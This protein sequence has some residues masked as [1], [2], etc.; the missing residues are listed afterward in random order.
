MDSKQ[1][2]NKLQELFKDQRII[3]WYDGGAEFTDFITETSLEDV[4]IWNLSEHGQLET[5]IE[6]EQTN[7]A[8]KYLLYAPFAKPDNADNWLLD[9]LLYSEEFRADKAA[10]LL[11][12][13]G[14]SDKPELTEHLAKR[15][16]FF[17]SKERSS[18]FIELVDSNDDVT[19]VDLKILTVLTKA[20]Y[21]SIDDILLSLLCSYEDEET[22]DLFSRANK[23]WD[24]I[25]K[26]GMA[27][28]F[29]Q[30]IEDEFSFDIE[31]KS[32]R[33]LLTRLMTCHL[34]HQLP[35]MKLPSLLHRYLLK[36]TRAQN[37]AAI[38]ISR[39]MQN[40]K[41][42]DQFEAYSEE[43]DKEIDIADYLKD[44]TV[45]DLTQTDCFVSI[46]KLIIRD[47]INELL[48]NPGFNRQR[49]K[50]TISERASKF[51]IDRKGGGLRNIYEAL[52][53][54]AELLDLQRT[55]SS[56]F[57]FDSA[58]EM[59]KAYES[60]LY[61]F[62]TAYRKFH[63]ALRKTTMAD[64]LKGEIREKVENVYINWFINNLSREWDR[65]IA[66][67]LFSNWQ[68]DS[69]T[70][71]Q[72]DFF[73]NAVS[74]KLLSDGKVFVII[75]DAMRYEVAAELNEIINREGSLRESKI[76]GM[77]GVL[78]SYTQLGM[79]ALLPHEE[80]KIND[81]GK[82]EIDNKLVTS[83]NRAE[84]IKAAIQ[85]SAAIQAEDLMTMTRQEGRGFL[86]DK[87]LVYVYHNQIDNIGDK[88]GTELRTFD[89]VQDTLSELKTMVNFI[90]SSLQVSR[91]LVTAD[92]G[93]LYQVN[94]MA[95][96]D[97]SSYTSGGK[98]YIA[99]KRYIIGQ[100]LA[101]Q[102]FAFKVPLKTVLGSKSS[103]EVVVPKGDGRFHFKGGARFVHGGAA[104]QEICVP[105]VE[106]KLFKGK[107]GDSKG[108]VEKVGV[109]LLDTSKKVTALTK[110]IMLFQTE[111]VKDKKQPVSLRIG[112][113][114]ENDEAISDE[115]II[116]FDSSNENP[117]ERQKKILVTLKSGDYKKNVDYY[118]M[119]VDKDTAKVCGRYP[120]R[121]SLGF[122]TDEFGF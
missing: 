106:V 19:A 76:N 34:N 63:F 103:T 24:E 82:V 8:G 47:I 75:S 25:V 122:S 118:L 121:I 40:E 2:I 15:S 107:K 111:P 119:L 27:E 71:R 114:T 64:I 56:S 113:Y 20:S 92:H 21:A 98:E 11:N 13:L 60:S 36:Q 105:L 5:K 16:D 95:E 120:Y 116:C 6:L 72:Q 37:H 65:F 18:R 66:N 1:I 90:T 53:A 110:S 58:A 38:F 96:S 42:N 88:A 94:P 22:D 77:L 68:L 32:L 99:K 89:A 35:K 17:K 83:S 87:K 14:L 78:P 109:E 57:S 39:W 69:A 46:D 3:F 55:Y 91:V 97:R 43:I 102:D 10:I 93:F 84:F 50:Q 29:W 48:N 86:K 73:R 79:A 59:F 100:D 74:P 104:L 28:C 81:E 4:S 61:R 45:N 9:V 49:L 115:Q 80:L 26:F 70:L 31:N 30:F 7:P 41:L 51:W 33:L 44:L 67:D 62:D 12:E 117:Q 101:E 23:R 108:R 85:E 112:F 52:A 54:V